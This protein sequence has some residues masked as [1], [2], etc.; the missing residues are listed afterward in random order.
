MSSAYDNLSP[1]KQALLALKQM[2][3]KLAAYQ[4]PIAVI[5]MGCRFPG[6]SNPE[7]YWQLLKEGQDAI[8]KVPPQHWDIEQYY[9]SD[10]NAPGKICT[11]YGGFV[12]Y[13]QEFEAPF[14]RIAPREATSLD[15]QQRLLLE[16]S[17]E[18]I[19]NAG[20]APQ[21]LMGSPTGVF[22]GI[23]SPDYW[24]QLL[25]REFTT[26]DAY[27]T[28]GNT[29]S[30]ASGRLSFHYGFQGPSISLDTAC[31]SAL[32]ALH[33]AIQSLR[34]QEC[35]MAVV[36]GVNRLISPQASINLS[37]SRMLSP[38]GRCKTFDD[39]A[40]GF[41]RSEGCGVI[42]I[43][44]LSQAIADRDR[45]LAVLK[46]S[47]VN[48]DGRT[49]GLTTPSSLSQAEVI[50]QALNNSQVESEQISYL[51]A[52]GTGTSLGD[53]IE[54]EALSKIFNAR[55]PTKP[56]VLGAVKTNI[57]HTEGASGIASLIK[58]ILALQHQ[59][60]P[61]NLN[62]NQ[63]NTQIDWQNLPFTLPDRAISWARSEQP[64]IAGISAFGFS[65]TNAHVVVEEVSLPSEPKADKQT[66][67][68]EILTLSAR[69]E[70]ALQQMIADY[71]KYLS[72]HPDLSLGDICFTANTG[73]S[74]FNYRLAILAN[75][76]AELLA[77]L[78][79]ITNGNTPVNVWEGKAKISE[80]LIDTQ[81][82]AQD[83]PSRQEALATLAQQYV[84]GG[85]IDWSG[86]YGKTNYHKITLPTYPFQ[87]QKYWF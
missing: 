12:P 13:L 69:S 37:K 28:T 21:Q 80:N 64:R 54:V 4:E 57:G 38:D 51:E 74:Q 76:T 14:F 11:P 5:G 41:V 34:N 46:G 8:T 44:R 7:A 68:I 2:R 39:N 16:V 86:L 79:Q 67:L 63:P 29:H 9:D 30:L 27:L 81:S 84:T 61:R 50:K 18:A 40:D 55:S 45:I 62:L 87:R 72:S 36:G 85:N 49:S 66:S 35:T 6:A 75:S 24:H 20:I 25:S 32:V 82:L 83:L 73:R 23:C 19:E 48:Q 52:H 42:L 65:G 58:V 53:L 3:Q 60:I 31:S 47:A 70:K 56:I 71:T 59:S 1:T 78:N 17:W 10:L 33:L 43:K 15:P 77:K 26:I 22:V